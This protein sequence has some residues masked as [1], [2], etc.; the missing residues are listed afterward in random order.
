MK[1]TILIFLLCTNFIYAHDLTIITKDEK[2]EIRNYEDGTSELHFFND[3]LTKII[4]LE[5]F[6]NLKQIRFEMTPYISDFNF[7]E[8]INSIEVIIF[9]DIKISSIDFLY[10]MKS[11]ERII[12]QSCVINGYI[13]VSKLPNLEYFEF[14]NSEI[15]EI[16]LFID[17]KT[18]LD[19]INVSYNKIDHCC[20]V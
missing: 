7:L 17:N 3:N 5:N 8:G 18:K 12:F 4:G 20:P 16:P 6:T 10:E 13:D 2:D 9:Q 1:N 19:I 15:T 14:T 11:L